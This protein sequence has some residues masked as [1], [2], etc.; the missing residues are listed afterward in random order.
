MTSGGRQTKPTTENPSNHSI[1]RKKK[2]PDYKP[3][4]IKTAKAKSGRDRTVI[5]S[6][7]LAPKTLPLF[8]YTLA[9]YDNAAGKGEPL[10]Q[11]TIIDPQARKGELTLLESRSKSNARKFVR[12]TCRDILDNPSEILVNP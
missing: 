2:T 10:A 5:V 6:W 4:K 12:L 11:V 3:I 8:S 1:D 7:K 9:V